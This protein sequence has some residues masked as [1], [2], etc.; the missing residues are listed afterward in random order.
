MPRN[1][2]HD[3]IT[4]RV[5]QLRAAVQCAAREY[6]PLTRGKI[7]RPFSHKQIIAK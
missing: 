7:T 2:A 6:L 1:T 3:E 5:G 4:A